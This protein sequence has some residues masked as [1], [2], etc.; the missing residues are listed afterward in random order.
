MKDKLRLAEVLDSLGVHYIEGGWPG[1]NPKDTA[2]FQ[3]V[4]K[5]KLKARLA[6]FGMTRR[7]RNK[8]HED[9]N[10]LNLLQAKTPTITVVGKS[11][12]FH[13]TKAL[14]I[15]LEQNLESSTTR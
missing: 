12:D 6:A 13:V 15:T 9:V 4:R 5:L 14:G 8:A 2:F 1:A 7:V 10:L 11:W 3:E